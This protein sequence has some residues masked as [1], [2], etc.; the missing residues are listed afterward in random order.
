MTSARSPTC[1]GCQRLELRPLDPAQ[2]ERAPEQLLHHRHQQRGADPAHGDQRPVQAAVGVH[3]L[4]RRVG[5][6]SVIHGASSWIQTT[7][8][9]RPTATA[10]AASRAVG[11]CL[12]KQLA[13]LAAP[14]P[15][16]GADHDH[17]D[18]IDPA[19]V[20]APAAILGHQ[21]AQAQQQHEGDERQH[22]HT[23]RT[24]KGRKQGHRRGATTDRRRLPLDTK[25]RSIGEP[26]RRSAPADVSDATRQAT[27]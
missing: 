10:T 14:P 17:A 3:R 9:S 4:E 23:R 20:D 25:G 18:G 19:R 11:P 27:A 24:G 13:V 12:A 5:G 21:A 7:N 26:P 16:H 2:Q 22:T 6:P 8:T 1:C 15:Q